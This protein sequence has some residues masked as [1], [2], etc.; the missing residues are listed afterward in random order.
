MELFLR[1]T[2]WRR[3]NY[4]EQSLWDCMICPTNKDIITTQSMENLVRN[5]R[6]SEID[7]CINN[8]SSCSWC[9]ALYTDAMQFWAL[10]GSCLC[11]QQTARRFGG[12]WD[13]ANCM[14]LHS[15]PRPVRSPPS[16]LGCTATPPLHLYLCSSMTA[17]LIRLV[18]SSPRRSLGCD[19]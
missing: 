4:Y 3:F 18:F 2:R 17:I 14:C 12:F 1:Q 9:N 19:L 13:E 10:E 15:G 6:H 11:R 16:H 7:L 8:P 5:C